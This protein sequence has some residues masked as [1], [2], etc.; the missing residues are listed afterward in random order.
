MCVWSVYTG[1]K[2]AAP[3]L[4]ESLEKI[5]GLWAGFYTGLVT[6]EN[7]RL[8]MGK[9]LGNM[10]VWSGKYKLEDFPGTSGLIH[11]RTNSGGD[12]R[13]GHPFVGSSGKVAIISQ[14]CSGIFA[15]QAIPLSEKWGNMMLK[16]GKVF[17]SG[18]Y[19]LP[20][21]YPV[22]SDGG[23]VHSAEVGCN[24]VEYY[25][26]K[27]GDPL[28]AMRKVFFELSNEAVSFFL[29]ADHPGVI[30]FVNSNQHA[31][32]QM[33]EDGV[34]VSIT[35]LGLPGNNGVEL[36]CNAVGLITPEKITFEKLDPRYETL[37]DIPEGIVS[38]ALECIKANPG[39]LLGNVADTA[40][41]PLF[42]ANTL[43]YRVGAAYRVAEHLVREKLI[44]IEKVDHT[45]SQG[46]PGTL[47]RLYAV[48]K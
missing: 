44:R 28:E 5:E 6:A 29:F 25:Y 34:L 3:L 13:W 41:K 22:L 7:G 24:A 32:Y 11:S 36:P 20:K 12:E 47:F 35:S 26:E 46:T 23:Q 15:D 45:S 10:D 1:K 48:E 43:N 39:F 38:A 19:G 37:F 18:I 14:G 9:V 31:V 21:R 27:L 42:P 8:H 30:G 2:T 17:T 33:R 40:L 16:E 4:W